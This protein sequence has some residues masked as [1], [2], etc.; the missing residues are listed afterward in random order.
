MNGKIH[1]RTGHEGPKGEY[2]YKGRLS[3]Q[4]LGRTTPGNYPVPSVYRAVWA[5][6]PVW[7]GPENL[8]LTGIRSPDR[9]L[10][11]RCYTEYATPAHPTRMRY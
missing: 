2:R 6:V 7:M 5:L 11:T 8:D 9:Q 10:V 1:T 3:T 4:W